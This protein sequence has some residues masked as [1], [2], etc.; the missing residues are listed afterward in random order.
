M[1]LL[2]ARRSAGGKRRGNLRRGWMDEHPEGSS[3]FSGFSTIYF[4]RFERLFV[5]F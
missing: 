4:W 5:G 2:G 3:G 1:A